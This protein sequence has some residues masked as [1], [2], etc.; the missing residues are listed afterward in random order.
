MPIEAG[1]QFRAR[2][3]ARREALAPLHPTLRWA[4]GPAATVAHRRSA[5]GTVACGAAG[6]L[7]LAGP[8]LPLCG[9][10]FT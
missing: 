1:A 7:V 10:C 2:R 8:G 5:D 3:L 4:V 6:P 9:V